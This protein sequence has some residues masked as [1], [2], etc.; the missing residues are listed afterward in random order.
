[1]EIEA[2]MKAEAPYSE[3]GVCAISKRSPVVLETRKTEKSLG[4]LKSAA[5]PRPSRTSS[6]NSSWHTMKTPF[7][8]PNYRLS[9]SVQNTFML[10]CQSSTGR[11]D[12]R[13][14]YGRSTFHPS[15]PR[16]KREAGRTLPSCSYG[17]QGRW[18]WMK[19]APLM[20]LGKK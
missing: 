18:G 9:P 7:K 8:A 17:S 6:H 5:V 2:V 15:S 19:A 1:M 10:D 11:I 4:V 13:Q 14:G 3:S 12:Q 16:E 20:K